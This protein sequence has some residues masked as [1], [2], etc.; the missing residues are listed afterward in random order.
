[1]SV[2][3]QNGHFMGGGQRPPGRPKGA[4]R[5]LRDVVPGA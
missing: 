1:V 5:A 2:L 4:A 3:P